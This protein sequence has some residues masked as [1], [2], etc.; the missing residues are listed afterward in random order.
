MNKKLLKQF[1]KSDKE[2]RVAYLHGTKY[3]IDWDESK[4]ELAYFHW[5]TNK[6]FSKSDQP[7]KCLQCKKSF[8]KDPDP[9]NNYWYDPCLGILPGVSDACCGHGVE[10]GYISFKNG[11]V[12]RFPKEVTIERYKNYKTKEDT[13]TI[14][15]TNLN[16]IEL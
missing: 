3:Y 2:Q 12:L 15:V 8:K 10:D 9:N 4:K 14:K 1:L 16:G 5:K 6:I 13:S 11:I 7:S